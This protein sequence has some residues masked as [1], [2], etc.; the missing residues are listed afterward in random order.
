MSPVEEERVQPRGVTKAE[1][2]S[3]ARTGS[4]A[5]LG[6]VLGSPL[7]LAASVVGLVALLGAVSTVSSHRALRRAGEARA[8][9]MLEERSHRLGAVIDVALE[10]ADPVLDR[11]RE[12]VLAAP[13]APPDGPE[14]LALLGR[15]NDLATSRRG[16][17]WISA[18]FP[19]GTFAGVYRDASE[20]LAA[21]VSSIGPSGGV[22]I[23]YRFDAAGLPREVSR[24]P[25]AYD[26]RTRGFYRE[27][28]AR[29]RRLWTDPYPFLPNLRTGVSRVE[30][31]YR[32]D[33][34]PSSPT[35]VLTVDFDASALAR[36]LGRPMFRGHRLFVVMGDGSVLGSM[37]STP[38][39]MDR[40]SR[41]RALHLED[42]HDAQAM[43][44]FRATATPGRERHSTL[45]LGGEGFR[46]GRVTL[47]RL[48][49]APMYL[50]SLVPTAPLYAHARRDAVRGTA[51]TI[52][53]SVV[54]L[55][56]S[57]AL[58]QSIARL[59][60]SRERAEREAAEARNEVEELGS[61]RLLE[62][63]GRG[64]MG[65]VYRARHKLLARDAALKL[66]A[67]DGFDV[68]DEAQHAAFFE[69]A[70]L[71]AR[72]RSPH[73]VAVYD[74]GVADD[75]RYFLAMELLDGLDLDALVR[76]Y[77]RQPPA[78]VA[79]IL[80]QMCESLAEAHA[81]GL[82]HRDVKPANVFLSR[83]G[84][85]LDV[86]KVLD[87]GLTRAI[88]K[89][90]SDEDTV[91]GTPAFMSPEQAVGDAVGPAADLY[92]LGCVGYFLLVGRPPYETTTAEA[93]MK[94]HVSEPVP[95]LPADLRAT[96]P[97]ALAQLLVR[98]MAKRPDR[99]PTSAKVLGE[100]LR[101]VEAECVETF[102]PETR[103]RWWSMHEQTRA[104]ERERAKDGQPTE[105]A[106][107]LPERVRPSLRRADS[108]RTV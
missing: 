25:T 47:T 92:A 78:R 8:E 22:E 77:G 103:E 16:L 63:L 40:R 2:P 34:G 97:P 91:E 53:A 85:T 57:L 62:L 95:E 44:A 96:V 104:A 105:S 58:S 20:K 11:L 68:D 108:V 35:A 84:D 43:A 9:S 46:V 67:A 49:E 76:R 93:A 17:T 94:A 29:G 81:A 28:V 80:A 101:R 100:A 89:R 82:V 19:D 4:L 1:P 18:S 102:L 5:R 75:G 37:G 24:T 70:R 51:V 73:T 65:E 39:P 15:M 41:V 106:T 71:L 13:E 27:A 56:L 74:F 14:L 86:V 99:R 3:G 7:A 26:P 36:L 42:F 31:V 50:L 66:I 32:D 30:P 33:S 10:A 87:F 107:R 6:H 61:Y 45:E 90:P 72:M 64:G 48:D 59:R 52:A 69:E 23:Q 21:Q 38:P 12:A 83:L 60:R 88:H 98:C 79:S 54:A 55:L